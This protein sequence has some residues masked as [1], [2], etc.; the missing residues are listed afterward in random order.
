MESSSPVKSVT[1]A[2]ALLDRIALGDVS[3]QGVTLTSLAQELDIPQ[4]TAHNLLKS[5]IASGY[6]AQQGRGVYVAG[7]KCAQISRLSQCA[8]PVIYQRVVAALHRFVDAEGEACVAT[9]LANGERITFAQVDSTHSVTVSHATMD[10]KPFFAMCTGRM[11]AACADEAELV[12][13]VSRH[14]M[15]GRHW[16]GIADEKRLRAELK[17]LKEQGWSL[18]HTP[19]DELVAM[20]CPISDGVRPAWG[21]LATYAPA[22]RCPEERCGQLLR[23][24]RTIAG[25]LYRDIERSAPPVR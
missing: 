7:P 14:G 5:L 9:V 8:D 3:R 24:L 20:A 11:L 16:E 2:M 21:T 15:P 4:N 6:V 13:I 25:D 17:R 10:G 18:V 19:Q 22:Y 1:K 23:R 12:Q